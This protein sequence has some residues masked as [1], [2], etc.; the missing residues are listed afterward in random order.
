MQKLV[1]SRELDLSRRARVVPQT[2]RFC[3]RQRVTCSEPFCKSAGMLIAIK[4]DVTGSP[5][6]I[7]CTSTIISLSNIHTLLHYSIMC[8]CNVRNLTNTFVYIAWIM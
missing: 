5:A 1:V 2:S 4:V 8:T 3:P 7:L 6:P